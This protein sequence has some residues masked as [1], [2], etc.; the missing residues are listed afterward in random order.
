VR[1]L[2]TSATP[3]E[4]Y[5]FRRRSRFAL[6]LYFFPAR[7]AGCSPRS[8]KQ[9]FIR[10]PCVRTLVL[11]APSRLV[12]PFLLAH[13]VLHIV[14]PLW[15]RHRRTGAAFGLL[16]GNLSYVGFYNIT[17]GVIHLPIHVP[18]MAMQFPRHLPRCRGCFHLCSSGTVVLLNSSR[19]LTAMYNTDLGSIESTPTFQRSLAHL[20]DGNPDRAR[21]SST[22]FSLFHRTNVFFPL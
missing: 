10:R 21:H 8:I 20:S 7:L 14:L 18:D 9:T 12:A 1:E 15:V 19:Y 4:P 16:A 6:A 3:S 2:H 5:Y 11:V 13:C 22:V 17:F